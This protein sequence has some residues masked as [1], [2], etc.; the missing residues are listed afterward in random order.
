MIGVFAIA[1][2][3]EVLIDKKTGVKFTSEKTKVNKTVIM[4]ML[5]AIAVILMYF[6]F[7]IPFIA[8]GFYKI[9]FSEVP[10]LI[11]CFTMGPLAGVGIELIKNLLHIVI[12]GTQTAGVGEVANFLIGCAFIVP[13]GLIYHKKHT[14]TGAL[15]G[16]ASGTVLMTVIG[17]LMNA[18]VLLPVYA[19]AFGMPLN[20]LVEMGTAI[21][22][23]ITSVSTL[24][25]FAVTPFN[26][27]KGVL[28][29][30]IVFLIYKKISPIFRMK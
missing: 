22:A 7:P 18:Y 12:S 13:A 5:S 17:G 15:I 25:L 26:L 4:A 11:G 1:R 28:V 9:D 24:I 20:A 14:R 27:L 6:D 21:N 16:M 23:K 3:S 2:G 30:L 10:V 19:K 29:S 8:P